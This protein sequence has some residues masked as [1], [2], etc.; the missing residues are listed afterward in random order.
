[1]KNFKYLVAALLMTSQVADAQ[2]VFGENEKEYIK[3]SA[4]STGRVEKKDAK[5]FLSGQENYK[6]STLGSNWFASIKAGMSTFTGAPVGCT[7]FFGHTRPTV[8]ASFGKWHSRY[9]GTRLVYQ[10]MTF[11]NSDN[12]GMDYQSFHGDLML[13]VSSCFR[14]DYSTLPKWDFIPYLGAGIARNASLK[15]Q[16]AA[17]S[18]GVLCSYRLTDRLHLTAELGGTSTF[19]KF[20]GKGKANHFGDNLIQ[21]AIGVSVG[22]GKQGYER[23]P[24]LEVMGSDDNGTVYDLTHYPKNSFDGLRSLRDRMSKTDSTDSGMASGIQL[25]APIL[26]FFKINT[27]NL[28][29]KQ[30]L[31]NIQEIADAVK[32]YDLQ[33]KIYG[34]ADSKTGTPKHNQALSV[35]R[36]KYIAKLLMKAGVDKSKMRGFSRGGINIY[37]PYTANRH[38]CVIVYKEK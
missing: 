32:E 21:A 24:V 11:T 3:T 15:K 5:P 19:Q 18:Y 36:A 22:I 17:I 12:E 13:N 37:K 1:M 28:V 4:F 7:D 33:V 23:K 38:T 26:F 9:F 2:V 25:D 34:A 16:Y 8:I 35:R 30:Q 29:D 14:S 27:T 6:L 20:D 31:V 10:G